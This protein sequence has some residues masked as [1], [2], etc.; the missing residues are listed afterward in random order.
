LEHEWEVSAYEGYLPG[1]E[2]FG[3][4]LPLPV[5]VSMEG[6]WLMVSGEVN[7]DDLCLN[8][9]GRVVRMRNADSLR[10]IPPD[11]AHY[12]HVAGMVSDGA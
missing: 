10:Y 1:G 5:G 11:M 3:N 12:E 2:S 7:L 8:K 9:P 6:V 4:L